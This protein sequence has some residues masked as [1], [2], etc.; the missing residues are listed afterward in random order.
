M[1]NER[2][3][4]RKMLLGGHAYSNSEDIASMAAGARRPATIRTYNS[5]L[6]KFGG[7]CTDH[8]TSPAEASVVQVSKFLMSLFEEGKQVNTIKNYRSA[9]AAIHRGFPDGST[10][11]TNGVLSQLLQGMSNARP[12]VRTLAPSWSLSGVLRALA[13]RTLRAFAFMFSGVIDS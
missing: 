12:V 8:A 2:P 1:K 3:R 13:N 10:M 6:A 5:R 4:S 9:I 7:W 11:G